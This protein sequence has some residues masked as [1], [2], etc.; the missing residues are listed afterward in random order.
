MNL[1][2]TPSQMQEIRVMGIKK[3]GMMPG[4]LRADSIT[5][6]RCRIEQRYCMH[7]F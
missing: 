1:S 5:Q 6:L 3:P 2:K 4:F 7:H